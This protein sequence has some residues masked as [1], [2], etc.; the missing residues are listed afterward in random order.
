M[1]HPSD[2]IRPSLVAGLPSERERGREGKYD[3]LRRSITSLFS[4]VYGVVE[5]AGVEIFHT[6][7]NV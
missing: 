6:L 5:A 1:K 7:C 4:F 2:P 3:F